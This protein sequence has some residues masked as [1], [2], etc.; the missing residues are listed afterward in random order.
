MLAGH[1]DVTCAPPGRFGVHNMADCQWDGWI[2]S[3]YCRSRAEMTILAV[4]IIR[5]EHDK[6]QQ[7]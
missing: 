7:N 5:C 2:F 4:R 6:L 1:D 3:D